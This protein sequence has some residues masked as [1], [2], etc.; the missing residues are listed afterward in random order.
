MQRTPLPAAPALQCSTA[1]PGKWPPSLSSLA[2]PHSSFSSPGKACRNVRSPA[3][4]CGYHA[5]AFL[6][7]RQVEQHG[8]GMGRS[9]P[10]H[11]ER[12]AAKLGL[13]CHACICLG[14]DMR[15]ST[16]TSVQ[17]AD[18]TKAECGYWARSPSACPFRECTQARQTPLPRWQCLQ[19]S[20]DG[21]WQWLECRPNHADV[22]QSR[23]AGR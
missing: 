16:R 15:R 4:H 20:E 19:R 11:M 12:S 2:P 5:R 7:S 17:S 18:L 8:V 9:A 21:R 13:G 6:L 22:S 14:D 23:A 10:L 3:S 1:L